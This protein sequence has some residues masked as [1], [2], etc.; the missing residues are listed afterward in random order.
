[1]VSKIT[2]EYTNTLT[3]LESLAKKYSITKN[4]ARATIERDVGKEEYIHIARSKGGRKIA[5][6][7]KKDM[8]FK[9]EYCK[10]M[11]KHVSESIQNKMQNSAYKE[12]W[13]QKAR[14]G[15]AKGNKIIKERLGTDADFYRNW[16]E[17]CSVGGKN[18]VKQKKGIFSED[19]PKRKEDSLKG[20]RRTTRTCIGPLG[21]RMYNRLE[22]DVAERIIKAGLKYKYE[23]HFKANNINKYITCDFLIG[24]LSMPLLLEVTYWDKVDEKSDQLNKKF[25][26]LQR[27]F[28][29]F[30]Y[31]V[32]TKKSFKGQYKR[33]LIENIRVI[34]PEK[35]ELFLRKWYFTAG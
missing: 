23:P 29:S 30:Q 6:R 5:E 11:R 1:M 17:R 3:N 32:V 22:S 34:T 28:K 12:K 19:Y 7:L 33:Y 8:S 4:E 13:E 20:L 10:K 24:N 21:E 26:E 9:K 2:K 25:R 31:I 15:S 14:R 35:L 27:Q 18:V 16:V